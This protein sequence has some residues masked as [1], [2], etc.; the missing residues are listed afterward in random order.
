MK[1]RPPFSSCSKT[2]VSWLVPSLLAASLVLVV[3]VRAGLAAGRRAWRDVDPF[4]GTSGTPVGGPIDTF[5]GASLPFGMIQW[6]PD[7][8]SQPAGGGYNYP[9]HRV[10]GF[11]LTHLSGPGCSV[12]GDF[13]I[14]PRVGTSPKPWDA[15]ASFS[16][17]TEVAHPGWYAVT[18]GRPPVRVRLTVTRRTGLGEFV[19][20][21]KRSGRVIF[22]VSS[23]Q[24]GVTNA[25]FRAIG[26]RTVVGEATSGGFC[27]APDRFR[28]Y[29]VARFDRPFVRT[30]T[31]TPGRLQRGARRVS[32]P[33][34]GGWVVF[35]ARGTNNAIKMK[36][37]ISYVGVR[38][39]LANLHAEARTWSLRRVRRAARRS[40]SRL[41]GRIVVRGGTHPERVTFYT[42]LYHTLLQPTLFND[43]TGEYPGFDGRIHRLR[44]GRTQYA[45]FSGWDIY[46]TE[47]PLLALLV[48]HRVDAMA[49]SLVRDA[50][51]G[52]LL[53]KWPLAN[54]YTGVMGG[55]AADP[56]LAGAYAFGARGFDARA[57]LRA[58]V[59]G[60]TDTS[61]RPAQGWYVERP[62]LASYLKRGYVDHALT[63]S[64]APVPNGA[65]ETLEYALDDFSIAVLARELGHPSLSRS[66]LKRSA[67]WSKIFDRSRGEM[68]PRNRAGAF[69]STPITVNGQSGF[70]EGNAAQYTWMVPEDFKDLIRGLGGR[71]ATVRRLNR[72][73]RHLNVGQSA[74]YAWLG[75]EP[76][77]GDPWV[78]LSALAPWRTQAVVRRAVTTLYLPTPAGLPGN[79]DLGT[80]S[81]WYIWCALGLYPQ[82][83]AVR[84]LDLGSPL[85]RYAR[86]DSP[87][88]LRIVI[89][90][91]RA[92]P[93]RPYVHGL[94]VDG[95]LYQRTW[96]ALPRKGALHLDF[97][98]G[99]RPDRSWGSAP[100][101]APPSFAPGPVH[102]PPS[103]NVRLL[104]TRQVFVHPGETLHLFFVLDGRHARRRT[105]LRWTLAAGP[106]L[107]VVSAR[108]GAVTLPPHGRMRLPLVVHVAPN[109]ETGYADVYLNA[110][111][112]RGAVLPERRLPL[113]VE[114]RPNEILPLVYAVN[115]ADNSV[116]AIN[117]R[118][119]ALGP[120]IAVGNDPDT[121]VLGLHGRHLY[122]A[123]QGSN[124]I[125][126]IDTVTQK[127]VATLPAGPGPDA[128]ALNPRGSTLWVA[129]G[130]SNSI[131]PIALGHESPGAPIIT[132]EAP[133]ALLFAPGGRILYVANAG[134][135]TVV[136]VRLPSRRVGSPIPVELRP[137]G[138]ALSIRKKRLY[139]V[140]QGA[141]EVTPVDLANDRAGRPYPTGLVPGNPVL[142]EE[143]DVLYV[144]NQ[145]TNTL[146]RIVTASG[147]MLEPFRAG[148]GPTTVASGPR[149]RSLYIA[150]SAGGR[151]LKIDAHT[152]KLVWSV[153]TGG[154]PLFVTAPPNTE[155]GR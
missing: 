136:G 142:V 150:D 35:P 129:D 39:A 86:I 88:G 6:S 102:F 117:P 20:P 73:F 23:D 34:S 46:R 87:Q 43:V 104:G 47:I 108:T 133:S 26:S 114:N 7:T 21:A 144:P 139:V 118:T 119:G 81:A 109:A 107:T 124:T 123:N 146:T 27:G 131:E 29:F 55:D 155:N 97:R 37:A 54:G 65:S 135:N 89:R 38:G 52:G 63:T 134:S 138:L 72:Y 113:R 69:L 148:L 17:A 137:V 51:Q 90:A 68:A 78:Y 19:F 140:D 5:P 15:T 83:P 12:F 40:W 16:H 77:L 59:R 152:G 25:R 66:F 132:G 75:N 45:N 62:G 53:P 85:F 74:P 9:D 4:I 95:A 22:K 28:V 153:R 30:G 122:V 42:A 64:V 145:A 149:G 79:D 91:R 106:G 105:R 56:I 11:G 130:G 125:S 49:E 44:P 13:D 143:N 80:M 154:L 115:N 120:R 76:S 100:A 151:V 112:Q 2:R 96:V 98:V 101:D 147:V 24:A 92:A 82:N 18:I 110:R 60:A 128:L 57:A 67:N 48:P 61:A 99:S 50:R 14:L 84:M 41:L 127:V 116:V 93:N 1:S 58:M 33:G 141:S 71:R 70:Q 94:R 111:T 31:W 126:V 103:T 3:P 10:L 36:V 8:P 121:A 32:G